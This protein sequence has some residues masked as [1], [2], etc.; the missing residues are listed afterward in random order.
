MSDP[1]I[2]ILNSS[3]IQR[4]CPK[5]YQL[6][7]RFF[8]LIEIKAEHIA[9]IK[10]EIIQ[11]L[12][13]L[14]LTAC[15]I[16]VAAP[17]LQFYNILLPQIVND[18][19]CAR[20]IPGLGFY[21]I[22]SSSVYD[23]LQ[24]QKKKFSAVLLLEF[25]LK[26]SENLQ[27]SAYKFLQNQS[28]IQSAAFDKLILNQITFPGKQILSYFLIRKKIMYSLISNILFATLTVL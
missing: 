25:F 27:I 7:A 15:V 2:L 3:F 12:A 4:F 8:L 1:F 17:Y 19:I 11:I 6:H 16:P 5:M 22:I 23:W 18:Y 21:I 9:N 26:R 24:I 20:L 14:L 13:D 10:I 28:H